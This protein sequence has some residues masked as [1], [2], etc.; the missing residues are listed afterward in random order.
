MFKEDDDDQPALM[1]G[2]KR[3]SLAGRDRAGSRRRG[4]GVWGRHSV[5]VDFRWPNADVRRSPPEAV[6]RL[7]EQHLNPAE[8]P[9][10]FQEQ[11]LPG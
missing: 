4:A 10:K 6:G 5:P 1:R 9:R 7:S 8:A 3:K 2:A 11:R